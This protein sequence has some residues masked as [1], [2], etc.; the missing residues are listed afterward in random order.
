MC[1][2]FFFGSKDYDGFQVRA[3]VKRLC[4]ACKLV[5]RRGRLRVVCKENPKH[6]QRQGIHGL[7]ASQPLSSLSMP[8][9]QAAEEVKRAAPSV[10]M[11]GGTI[12]SPRVGLPAAAR[13]LRTASS[14]LAS[15]LPW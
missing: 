5:R 12:L 11:D 14:S 4:L 8:P 1:G 6:K 3:S 13:V 10:L 2:F 9:V 7:A 15:P